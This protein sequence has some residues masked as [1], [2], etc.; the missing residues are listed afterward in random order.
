MPGEKVLTVLV[1]PP[2][3]ITL[4]GATIVAVWCAWTADSLAICDKLRAHQ[5]LASA[6][7]HL[8]EAKVSL[9]GQCSGTWRE[10][11]ARVRERERASY[12]R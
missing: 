4:S 7:R 12:Q 1:G 6:L 5:T 3:R 9:L 10:A 11:R 8:R 2:N